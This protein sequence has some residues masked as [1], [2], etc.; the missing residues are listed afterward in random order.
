MH[1]LATGLMT[2]QA[3]HVLM[4]IAALPG[5]FARDSV[6][7]AGVLFTGAQVAWT[8][9]GVIAGIFLAVQAAGFF[10]GASCRHARI[11]AGGSLALPLLGSAGAVTAF[12]L[13]PLALIA[14]IL[15]RQ[16]EWQMLFRD[17]AA[18]QA[19]E[20][21]E[22]ENNESAEEEPVFDSIDTVV[23]CLNHP[24][25]ANTWPHHKNSLLFFHCEH[26]VWHLILPFEQ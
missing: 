16:P 26:I 24:R 19:Y 13:I 4:N 21:A 14:W 8:I 25:F 12:A 17:G 22:S 11:S 3:V 20:A 2:A 10:N 6:G 15:L 1:L 18:L 7:V 9:G 23:S 5:I